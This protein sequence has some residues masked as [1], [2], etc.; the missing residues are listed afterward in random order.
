MSLKF[1]KLFGW[2]RQTGHNFFFSIIALP[3]LWFCLWEIS[4][5]R[6][7]MYINKKKNKEFG[8]ERAEYYALSH[9]EKNQKKCQWVPEIWTPF[10]PWTSPGECLNK[11]KDKS[12]HNHVDQLQGDNTENLSHAIGFRSYFNSESKCRR[13]VFWQIMYHTGGS[14]QSVLW[15]LKRIWRDF[16][17][18]ASWWFSPY[19]WEK[20]W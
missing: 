5:E 1:T 3:S 14:L 15:Q 20:K 2:N 13:T 18:F 17:A 4:C 8:G 19:G 6:I 10:S 16:S 9:L 7:Y 12:V 11:S